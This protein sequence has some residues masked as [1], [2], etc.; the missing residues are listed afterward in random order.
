MNKIEEFKKSFETAV[1]YYD[2][3]D[4]AKAFTVWQELA[5]QGFAKAQHVVAFCYQYGLGTEKD[6]YAALEWY[7]KAAEQ[8]HPQS[9]SYMAGFYEHGLA[10]LEKNTDEAVRLWRKAAELGDKEAQ[11][12]LGNLYDFGMYVEHNREEAIRWWRRS[13]QQLFPRAIKR[14]RELGEWIFDEKENEKWYD[15]TL[16]DHPVIVLPESW[17]SDNY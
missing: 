16:L 3:G 14:M 17:L 13:A 7:Q 9:I 8:N 4:K 5:S 6:E 10:G 1:D 11:F 2:S 15:T 12:T